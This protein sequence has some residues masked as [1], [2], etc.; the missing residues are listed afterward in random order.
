MNKIKFLDINK[1]YYYDGKDNSN[2]LLEFILDDNETILD[3]IIKLKPLI[4]FYIKLK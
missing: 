3:H 4:L 2:K 1:S